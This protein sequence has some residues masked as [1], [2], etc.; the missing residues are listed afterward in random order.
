MNFVHDLCIHYSC[1]NQNQKKKKAFSDKFTKA[2][3]VSWNI[4]QKKKY[5]KY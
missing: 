1:E 2:F 5:I 4:N 3:V